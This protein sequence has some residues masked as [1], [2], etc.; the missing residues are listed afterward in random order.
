MNTDSPFM[1]GLEL[2]RLFYTETVA[3]IL[4]KG[5]PGL[6]HSA[7]LLGTGSEV[8]GLDTVR[9]TDHWWA[10]RVTLFVRSEDYAPELD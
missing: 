4:A 5:F 7:G 10:P 6:A 2:S 1:P 8:L 9:S 3:P